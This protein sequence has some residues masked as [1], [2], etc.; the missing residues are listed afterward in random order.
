VIL[1]NLYIR[2]DSA[3]T[4]VTEVAMAEDAGEGC[5]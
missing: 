3:E 2:V 5:A 1:D 4:L